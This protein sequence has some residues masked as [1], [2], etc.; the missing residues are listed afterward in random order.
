MIWIYRPYKN[1]LARKRYLRTI[2][3]FFTF[4]LL[5]IAYR[6]TKYGLTQEFYIPSLALMLS[7][8][9]FSALIL[10][11]PRACYTDYEN[12]YC[13]SKRIKK[14]S[15]TFHPD[16]ENL[17]VHVEGDKKATLYFEKKEDLE[18]FLKEVGY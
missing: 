9:F 18:K 15:A 7:L 2:A 3:V 1:A 16:Y 5:L 12:I 17:A 8:L 4:A 11:K 13:G 14:A 6:Y 10:R